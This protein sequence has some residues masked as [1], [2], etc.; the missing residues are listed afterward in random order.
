MHRAAGLLEP[1]R[2]RT[3]GFCR[4]EETQVDGLVS[5]PRFSRWDCCLH[6]HVVMST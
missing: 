4:K 3:P 2:Q 5:A 6:P 1:G